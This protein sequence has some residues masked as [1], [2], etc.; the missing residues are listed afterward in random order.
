MNITV[1][2][3]L[4][5]CD[6][7]RKK[8]IIFYAILSRTL[9]WIY[10]GIVCSVQCSVTVTSHLGSPRPVLSGTG[11]KFSASQ[12]WMSHPSIFQPFPLYRVIGDGTVV[13]LSTGQDRGNT[14]GG[15]PVHHTNICFPVK[16][17]K[18]FAYHTRMPLLLFITFMIPINKETVYLDGHWSIPDSALISHQQAFGGLCFNKPNVSLVWVVPQKLAGNSAM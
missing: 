5:V 1:L 13:Y 8:E 6:I 2:K 4:S 18:T 16:F 12:H 9:G 3:W 17:G 10:Y 11:S 7:W 14:K 15:L